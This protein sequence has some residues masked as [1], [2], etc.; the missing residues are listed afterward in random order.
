MGYDAKLD[1]PIEKTGFGPKV[2]KSIQTTV[3]RKHKKSSASDKTPASPPSFLNEIHNFRHETQPQICEVYRRPPYTF[4]FKLES[5]YI[6]VKSAE[7]MSSI[8]LLNYVSSVAQFLTFS[9]ILRS[10]LSAP[11][12]F[13]I[14]DC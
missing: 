12:Y 7:G 4:S 11:D 14:D 13:S 8:F 10:F 6:R 1:G 9:S 5:S 3:H 2:G